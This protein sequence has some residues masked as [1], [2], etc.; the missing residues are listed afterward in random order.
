MCLAS[1][2]GLLAVSQHGGQYHM[3]G[4]CAGGHM[5]RQEAIDWGRRGSL[6]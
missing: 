1:G 2:E 3:A 4:V 5:E 6:L